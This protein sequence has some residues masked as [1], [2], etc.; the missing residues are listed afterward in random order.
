M[1]IGII[2]EILRIKM[3]I[4]KYNPKKDTKAKIKLLLNVI[5]S[6]KMVK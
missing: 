1:A 2:I 6:D 3:K 4:V 5:N